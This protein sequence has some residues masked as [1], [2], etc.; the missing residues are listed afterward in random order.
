MH[1]SSF[2]FLGPT[3][4]VVGIDRREEGTGTYALF[5]GHRYNL[6]FFAVSVSGLILSC[7][8]YLLCL[9]G[10]S[11]SSPMISHTRLICDFG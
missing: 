4:P 5:W 11:A 1:H 2:S 7:Y 10:L 3:V 6:H 9:Q 8:T